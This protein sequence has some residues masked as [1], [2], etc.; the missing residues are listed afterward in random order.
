[1]LGSS[2]W[3]YLPERDA[4]RKH[5]E[6][7]RRWLLLSWKNCVMVLLTLMLVLPL[8]QK[9]IPIRSTYSHSS[10]SIQGKRIADNNDGNI[11]NDEYKLFA[12]KASSPHKITQDKTQD[13]TLDIKSDIAKD[14][15]RYP[16]WATPCKGAIVQGFGMGWSEEFADYRYSDGVVIKAAAMRIHPVAA[17]TVLEVHTGKTCTV[18][19]QHDQGYISV[20]SGMTTLEVKDGQQVTGADVIGQIQ[21]GKLIKVRM[22]RF[23]QPV[24]PE[25]LIDFS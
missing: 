23:A 18:K 9:N 5:W 14:T 13:T 2:A 19:I 6:W 4:L 7:L 22:E 15:A 8:L 12:P 25:K 16:K 10:L 17:G 20:L 21:R 24:D 1:M 3:K 11:S